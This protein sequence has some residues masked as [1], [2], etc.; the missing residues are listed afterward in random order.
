MYIAPVEQIENIVSRR[1]EEKYRL[2]IIAYGSPSFLRKAFLIGCTDYLKNHWTVDEL[3]V[4]L[5]QAKKHCER[6]YCFPWGN[7][8]FEGTRVMTINGSIMLSFQEYQILKVLL[9]NRG[10]VVSRRAL[11]Y[12]IWNSEGNPKSRVLDVHVSSIR[13]KLGQ[14]IPGKYGESIITPIRGKGYM[15]R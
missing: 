5:T 8:S 10:T 13:R 14:I 2:P 9:Q 12:A 7:L 15:I 3:D 6:L 11:F 4:R 1:K